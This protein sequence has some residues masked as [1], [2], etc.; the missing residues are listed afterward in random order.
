MQT[1]SRSTFLLFAWL[2]CGIL[3]L[4]S[5]REEISSND[6]ADAAR[7][8]ANDVGGLVR[9]L[10][11]VYCSDASW[12]CEPIE[13]ALA[14]P[15]KYRLERGTNKGGWQQ[16]RLPG[17]HALHF[18]HNKKTGVARWDN[19][20]TGYI[21]SERWSFLMLDQT[22]KLADWLRSK[23]GDSDFQYYDMEDEEDLDG[24]DPYRRFEL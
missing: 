24:D 7:A 3:A 1:H 10:E 2:C 16:W 12:K 11:V 21:D 20:A 14:D 13:V 22:S 6:P 23:W 8:A 15:K 17:S 9:D 18:Y 5:G 19:P 4:S